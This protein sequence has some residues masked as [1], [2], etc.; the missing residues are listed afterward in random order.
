[1]NILRLHYFCYFQGIGVYEFGA[2]IMT[3]CI[4]VVN[5]K[6]YNSIAVK[7]LSV[8]ILVNDSVHGPDI[9]YCCESTC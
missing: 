2:V 4:I 5:I 7:L 1:M 8:L 6:V 3:A 9:Y